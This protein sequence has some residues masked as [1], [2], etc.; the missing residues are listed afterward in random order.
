M[1]M[2]HFPATEELH[3]GKLYGDVTLPNHREAAHEEAVWGCLL[4]YQPV[5]VTIIERA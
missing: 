3:T 4:V 2:R 5:I 1:D